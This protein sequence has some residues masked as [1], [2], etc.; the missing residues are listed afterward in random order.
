MREFFYF[1]GSEKRELGEVSKFFFFFWE[2]E[3]LL[4]YFLYVADV[5]NCEC[6]KSYMASTQKVKKWLKNMSEVLVL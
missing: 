2:G 6:S 5:K 1:I 3:S 4:I